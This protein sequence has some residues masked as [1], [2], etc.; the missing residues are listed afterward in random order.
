MKASVLEDLSRNAWSS[1][2]NLKR[3]SQPLYQERLQCIK[4]TN[5]PSQKLNVP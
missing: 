4:T 1:C 5:F 2:V 3:G